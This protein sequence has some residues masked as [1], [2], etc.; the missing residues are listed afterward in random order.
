MCNDITFVLKCRLYT[1]LRYE[2][3]AKSI[4]CLKNILM[5]E[6]YQ[7]CYYIVDPKT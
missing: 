1:N 7:I 4:I 2:K 5:S 3:D 6:K